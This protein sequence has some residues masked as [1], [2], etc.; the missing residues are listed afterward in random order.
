M[1]NKL[2]AR[3]DIY[4]VIT[5]HGETV[6][7][8]I[9]RVV[10]LVSSLNSM[11]VELDDS[12]LFMAFLNR[13]P[14][15][16]FYTIAAMDTL[17]DDDLCLDLVKSRLLQEQQKNAIR[18]SSGKVESALYTFLRSMQTKYQRP[19]AFIVEDKVTVQRPVGKRTR[20]FVPEHSL[21]HQ[22]TSVGSNLLCL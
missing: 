13:R 20:P 3:R 21:F 19:Q 9:K 7:S 15:L 1:L 5:N 2:H 11:G 4:T 6:I 18:D 17:S 22:N 14:A 16:F 8:F 10:H 12:E